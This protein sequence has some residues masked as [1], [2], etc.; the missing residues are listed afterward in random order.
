[1]TRTSPPP[2]SIPQPLALGDE[3]NYPAP[4]SVIRLRATLHTRMR[5][6]NVS[7]CA[8]SE[9]FVL[10]VLGDS[11]M[12]EFTEGTIVV[13]E[14]TGVIEHGCY[15]VAQY[16]EEYLLRQLIIDQGRFFLKP[17][18]DSYPTVEAA[19]LQAI[20]GRVIQKAGKYRRDRK[21]YL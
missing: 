4:W 1:L 9:P 20:K 13:V 6:N 16:G 2:I 12:P 21:H 15:V 8:G 3:R 18:N 17:L 19:G 10:R 14:P 7:A 11:M 5:G